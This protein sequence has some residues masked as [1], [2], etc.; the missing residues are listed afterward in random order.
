MSSAVTGTGDMSDGIALLS[1][2][3]GPQNAVY[4]D[5]NLYHNG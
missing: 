1:E 4:I 2:A 3:L 5:L